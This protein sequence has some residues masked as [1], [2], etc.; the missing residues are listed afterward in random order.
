[1]FN[2]HIQK[3]VYVGGTPLLSVMVFRARVRLR[4]G[5]DSEEVGHGHVAY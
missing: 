3:Y 4:V 5:D 2:M 1:M